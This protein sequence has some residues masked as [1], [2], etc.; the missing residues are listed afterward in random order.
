MNNVLISLKSIV[1]LSK[2]ADPDEMA[3]NAEF[4]QGSHC[5]P[6]LPSSYQL[7]YSVVTCISTFCV[8][9]GN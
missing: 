5:F 2:S 8:Y 7:L 9:T 6:G 4:H 3:H 1:A